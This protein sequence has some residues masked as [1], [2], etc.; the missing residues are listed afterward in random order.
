MPN[1]CS[2]NIFITGDEEKIK[3]LKNVIENGIPSDKRQESNVFMTL[4]GI[5]PNMDLLEYETKWYG[6]NIDNWGTKWD[7]SYDE[8]YFEF[9]KNQIRMSP[10][11]AWSPPTG[12]CKSLAMN[13]GVTVE[14]YYEEPGNDFC[15]KT[16]ITEDGDVQEEDYGYCEGKY[17]FDEEGF[18]NEIINNIEFA[19]EDDVPL[20][21]FVEDYQYVSEE[22][23]KEI[24]KLYNESK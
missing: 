5:P 21:E 20:E 16:I 13:Y 18:W 4:V 22:D 17:H 3:F 24:E 11:T 14:M 19:K 12:F 7:V 6:T 10:D 9:D 2:N 1:W 8:S 15:G 23:K